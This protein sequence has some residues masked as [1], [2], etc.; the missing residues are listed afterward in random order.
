MKRKSKRTSEKSSDIDEFALVSSQCRE[1]GPRAASVADAEP[2]HNLCA[3]TNS[4]V[5]S[6]DEFAYV[7]RSSDLHS[8]GPLSD[9]AVFTTVPEE[10]ETCFWLEIFGSTSL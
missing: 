2:A 3:K 9:E 10:D 7:A 8:G 6:Q 1:S 5:D 4:F